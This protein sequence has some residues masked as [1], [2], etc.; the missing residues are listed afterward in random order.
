MGRVWRDYLKSCLASIL[1]LLTWPFQ[2]FT[3]M[4]TLY[5]NRNLECEE[6]KAIMKRSKWQAVGDQAGHLLP[7]AITTALLVL[8]FSQVYV[9]DIGVVNRSAQLN[10]L[11]FA[12]KLHEILIA[13]SLSSI[14][15][16]CVQY[17]LLHGEGIPLGGLLAGFQVTNL[18]SLWSPG[19]WATI[20]IG[21]A[22]ARR[23]L[24][25]ILI[26]TLVT[27]VAIVGP[28]S[29]ILMLPSLDW[30]EF[31]MGDVEMPS[32]T[33]NEV[34][35]F[36][37][38]NE[39]TLWPTHITLDNF[40]PLDCRSTNETVPIY[41]PL[42]AFSTLLDL[43]SPDIIIES[44]WRDI[45]M[46]WNITLPV[47]T[48]QTE[49][50]SQYLEGAAVESV[51]Q[52][53]LAL[54]QTSPLVADILL[55]YVQTLFGSGPGADSLRFSLSMKNN[56]LIPAPSTYALC[57]TGWYW[58]ESGSLIGGYSTDG[59]ITNNSGPLELVFPLQNGKT[60][61]APSSQLLD[62]WDN[63]TNYATVWVEPPDS[64][65]DSPSIGVVFAMFSNSSASSNSSD[66]YNSG[67]YNASVQCCS[68]VSSWEPIEL[69]TTPIADTYLHSPTADN[70]GY[71]AVKNAYLA[72]F[73]A[74]KFDIAWAES[75]IPANETLGALNLKLSGGESYDTQFP[76]AVSIFV[77]NVLS[78]L[79]AN[80]IDIFT[81]SHIDNHIDPYLNLVM[82]D[83]NNT[84]AGNW[85][86]F[87]ASLLRNGYS[88]SM[89]GLTR[90]LATGIL[91]TYILIA[92]V[93]MIAV[94]RSG[95][96]C[97]GLQSLIEIVALAINSTPT[98]TLGN[99]SAGISRFNTYKHI[100]K[101][102]AVSNHQHLE[103]VFDGDMKADDADEAVDG[104]MYG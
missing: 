9:G 5:Q 101:V 89:R 27:L 20:S 45:P 98:K 47:K 103:I 18:G 3:I 85:T 72:G 78:R 94:I 96:K 30:W 83:T 58:W 43:V 61:S 65:T 79:G 39:S 12:A 62:V 31:Q 23:A 19:L 93:Y 55:S 67:H 57:S 82:D 54:T 34:R 28:A 26:V 68:V 38:A 84:N 97:I 64:E 46:A 92:V 81:G 104:E 76:I 74:I 32:L 8:N 91:L 7:I 60:W 13:A 25:A 35:M 102:R 71:S 80:I 11:Q 49:T 41:C 87:K 15:L 70:V 22:K 14:V 90:R 17:E 37:G 29:A 44:V 6:P 56:S 50:L 63:S 33:I 69:Y 24:L 100:V 4:A 1:Y 21:A 73:E 53:A 99:T 40:Y 2:R 95:W 16:H 10:A 36:I 52:P 77:T 51:F 66:S 42:G 48:D 86:E 59:S 75:T 88:Y